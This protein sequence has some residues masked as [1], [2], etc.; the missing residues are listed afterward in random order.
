MYP[1]PAREL[2]GSAAQKG[3]CFVRRTISSSVALRCERL[4]AFPPLP[5]T[6][7]L[8]ARLFLIVFRDREIDNIA[9]QALHLILHCIELI[10]FA[11][12]H[13]VHV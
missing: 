3:L 6:A 10:G 5:Y 7:A 1:A 2:C 13:F 8:Y 12:F 11:Y 9:D 4:L